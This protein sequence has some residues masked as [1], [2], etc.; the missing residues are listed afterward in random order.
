MVGKPTGLIDRRDFLKAAGATFL[1][2]LAPTAFADTLAADAVFATAYQRRDGAYGAAILSEAGKILHTIELPDRGHDITF[3]PVS[4]RSVVFARQP[5]TFFVAFDLAGR[6]PPVT[7]HSV[8]SRHFFGHGVFSPDG[9]L[10][11]ATENDFDNAAGMVG[12]YDARSGFARIGEFPTYG[13]GPHEL[14][15]LA[16]GRTIAVANGGIETHPDFGRAKLNLPTMKP[17]YALVDRLT[18]DL[19]EKHELPPEL[20]QLSI[21]HIDT[22][23]TGA[24]WFGCQHE[25]PASERPALV[26]RAVRGKELQLI[27]MAEDVLS[28]FRN[29]IGSVAANRDAGT[30]AV[31]SPQGNSFA[32]IEAASAK[33]VATQRLTEVCGIAPDQAGY[34]M[35]TGT[36]LIVEPDGKSSEEEDYVWDNHV[37]RMEA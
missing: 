25:G 5:G 36:G 32:V 18:G 11:Y 12:V 20:H 30:V 24:V 26:G 27:E 14:L 16:D 28:G 29:Y 35:T 1:S 9:A 31:T 8:A 34:V 6:Q 23:E 21:R 10:L 37:L 17:S 19:I 2:S 22:D 13:V 7:V 15:L 4:G 33:V 3:D